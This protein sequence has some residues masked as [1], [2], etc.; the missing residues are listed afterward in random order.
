M[1][2]DLKVFG[3]QIINFLLLFFLLRKFLWNKF[4]GILDDRREKIAKELKSIEDTKIEITRLQTEYDQ[5]LN[6]IEEAARA[7]I[8]SAIMEGQ[9]I[10]QDI[11]Q[12]AKS[13]ADKILT[14]AQNDIQFEFKKAKEEL[15]RSVIDL[16]IQATERL[17][18]EKLNAETDKK[19]VSN[20]LQEL[21]SSHE[22]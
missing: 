12:Q 15:R 21:D 4:L 14:S 9:R 16:T 2:F 19:L 3:V 13:E 10:S 18:Q 6:Q 17:I 7:R 8:Q 22:R 5:K 20:L 1:E 11:L